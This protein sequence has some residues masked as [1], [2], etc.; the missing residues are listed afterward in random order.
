M[1]AYDLY[2]P[3]NT[4]YKLSVINDLHG[5]LSLWLFH[6]VASDRYH[7]LCML[8]AYENRRRCCIRLRRFYH[9]ITVQQSRNAIPQYVQISKAFLFVE[10]LYCS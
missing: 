6:I 9:S 7:V 2:R 10:I 1:I 3:L 5:V 8:I 4:P